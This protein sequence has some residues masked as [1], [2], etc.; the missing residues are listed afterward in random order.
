MKA[1]KSFTPNVSNGDSKAYNGIYI[2]HHC[3]RDADSKKDASK[4]LTGWKP[5]ELTAPQW[6]EKLTLGQ[7]I[8]PST[9]KPR[10][11]GT[12]THSID[13]WTETYFICADADNIRTVEYNHDGTDKNA[14]GIEPFTEPRQLFAIAPFLQDKVYAITESVSSMSYDKPPPHRRYRLIFLFDKPITTPEHYH[15]ILRVFSKDFPIIP[16]EERSPAQPVYGNARKETS[17]SHLFGNILRLSDFPI[18]LESKKTKASKPTKY[19]SKPFTGEADLKALNYVPNDCPYETWRAI[20]MAIKDAGFSVGV[21][22]TWSGGQR[23]NSSGEWVNEDIQAHWDRYKRTSG[24]LATWG[25]VMHIAMQHGYTPPQHL[26]RKPKLSR[27]DTILVETITLAES[28]RLR[29]IASETFVNSP[30]DKNLLQINTS[31]DD[32]GTGKTTT[33]LTTAAKAKRR[34]LGTAETTDLSAQQVTQA[35][36]SGF[37]NPK[38]LFGRGSDW[39]D[40]DDP[41]SASFETH[42]CPEYPITKM[43]EPY[44][45]PVRWYCETKC[46]HKAECLE[47]GYLSQ[48]KE[49]DEHDFISTPNPNLFFDP[50]QRGYLESLVSVD[51]EQESDISLAFDA[52]TGT[53]SSPKEKEALDYGIIDDYAIA[54][55]FTDINWKER[56][57]KRVKKDWGTDTPTS[58]FASKI[59]KAFKKKKPQKIMK[60]L[61]KAYNETTDDHKEIAERLTQHARHG[62]VIKAFLPKHHTLSQKAVEYVDGGKQFIPNPDYEPTHE[63]VMRL[64]VDLPSTENKPLDTDRADSGKYKDKR[65]ERIRKDYAYKRLSTDKIPCIRADT[66]DPHTAIGEKVIVPHA[67][68]TALAA[69]IKVRDLTPRWQK[70]TTPIQLLKMLFD[71][72]ENDKNAPIFIRYTLS[73]ETQKPSAVLSF[74]IPPQAPAGIL[75]HLSMLSATVVPDDLR[76]ILKGQPVEI[77]EQGGTPIEWAEDIKA[78]QYSDARLTSG[79]IFEYQ[80]DTDGKRLLQQK[81]TGLTSLAIERLAKINDWAK[82]TEGLTSFISYKD[83]KNDFSEHLDGFDVITHFDRV[84]GLNFDGLKLLVVFGY[85]KVSHEVVM[86]HARQ[87]Y[88]SDSEPLPKGIPNL[89]DEHDNPISEYLQL[90]NETEY[91]EHGYTITERRYNNPRLENIRRQ[92]A[93]DKLKQAIGRARFVRWSGTTIVIF[94][95]SPIPGITEKVKHFGNDAFKASDTP[96]QL[97]E[98]QERITT[99]ITQGDVK[100]IMETKDV[101]K[102]QAY[103][104]T[105]ETRKQSK[106]ERDAQVIALHQQGMNKSEIHRK[107][108][109]PRSTVLDIIKR[110]EQGDENSSRL[111]VYINRRSEKPSPPTNQDDTGVPSLLQK[112][113]VAGVVQVEPLP[114]PTPGDLEPIPMSEYS[115]LDNKT[116]LLELERCKNR[117][118]YNGAALLQKLL[119]KRGITAESDAAP[120]FYTSNEQSHKKG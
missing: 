44:R 105:K 17:R 100:A 71:Y 119:R 101:E 73:S 46:K 39:K 28:E 9:F 15:F 98:S 7:T 103:E 29:K 90:T 75:N 47:C 109:V 26:H 115:S 5:I 110:L 69:G 81:P 88:A 2:P 120:A 53:T 65:L 61:R 12:Y 31:R 30:T 34:T 33:A 27:T 14:S 94:T 62:I 82:Q 38:Q 52:M 1:D 32:T 20:G 111:L 11:N 106:D 18:T 80:K 118:N 95:N 19:E 104:I 24:K 85:P 70:N 3:V 102:S 91:T 21:F 97:S 63:Q 108:G 116:A 25:T 92:L 54:S 22:E 68:S 13:T 64:A 84:A 60:A 8:Q 86:S 16:P 113:E 50:H 6:V 87:Q 37:K 107:T 45:I 77:T 57:F 78:F 35:R 51:N 89:K 49:L 96:R 83:L 4:T 74:S 41:D 112:K 114:T 56:E 72:V 23:K 42:L 55:L 93:T 76:K 48:F 10:A 79:S 40:D 117:N 59:L 99:A 36:Q 43:L 66:F 58:I 67:F